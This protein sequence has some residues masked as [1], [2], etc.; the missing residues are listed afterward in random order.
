M[1]P[2]RGATSSFSN[3]DVSLCLS[4]RVSVRG[5]TWSTICVQCHAQSFTSIHAPRVRRNASG[6]P[7]PVRYADSFN[8]C[9]RV[10]CNLTVKQFIFIYFRPSIYASHAG[11]QHTVYLYYCYG[12]SLQSMHPCGV[13]PYYFLYAVDVLLQSMHLVRGATANPL[14][15]LQRWQVPSIHAPRV[16]CNCSRRD[17]FLQSMHP[18]VGCNA[19]PAVLIFPMMDPSIHAPRVGCNLRSLWPKILRFNPSIHAPHAGCNSQVCPISH[20]PSIHAPIRVQLLQSL[21]SSICCCTFN[22]CTPCGV[23][24]VSASFRCCRCTS[25][26]PRIHAGCNHASYNFLGGWWSFNPCT[27]AG[28]NFTVI[29]GLYLQSIHPCGCNVTGNSIPCV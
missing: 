5:A 28:R 14:Q 19:I 6:S 18:R 22:P 29:H 25:F 13:Q 24:P 15:G 1:H 9:T 11:V 21:F 27:H 7:C 3:S 16:G 4:I 26:N 2:T 12:L 20:L 23:Q 10:G 17:S 8:P